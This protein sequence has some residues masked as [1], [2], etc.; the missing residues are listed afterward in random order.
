[1]GHQN[2]FSFA[3]LLEQTG[4]NFKLRVHLKESADWEILLLVSVGPKGSDPQGYHCSEV[5][6]AYAPPPGL[7][8]QVG[9]LRTQ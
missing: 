2:N 4:Q 1:M 6:S 7:R 9:Y 8:R 3:S 5:R